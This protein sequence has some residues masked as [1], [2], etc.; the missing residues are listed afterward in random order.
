MNVNNL[1]LGQQIVGHVLELALLLFKDESAPGWLSL[2]LIAALVVLWTWHGLSAFRLRRAINAA[3]TVLDSGSGHITKERFIRIDLGFKELKDAREPRRR[4]AVAW[5]EFVETSIPPASES[6]PLSNTVRPAAFF[7]REE[8]GLDRGLWRQVPA[9]FVSV[10]LFLTFLGLVAALQ[11]TGQILVEARMAAD[12]A[13]TGAEGGG[14]SAGLEELL[15]IAKTKFI[16]SLTGLLCSI[17][18]TLVLRHYARRIDKAL[19]ALCDDIEDG[20]IFR[21]EQTILDQVLEQA[22]E[23]TEHL[24]TFSTELVAQIAAPLRDDLPNTIRDAMQQAMEPVIESISRG[25]NEGV[26]N[27]VDSVRDQLVAGIEESVLSMNEAIREVRR[28]LEVVTDRLDRSAD[29]MGERMDDA[30][31]RLVSGL[32]DATATMRDSLLDPLG[33]LVERIRGLTS[34]VGTAAERIDRYAEAVGNSETGIASANEALGR[35][36]ETLTAVSTPVRDAVSAI[37]STTGTMGD[38]V[39]TASEAMRQ[40]TAHTEA[41]LRSAREGIEA[42]RS[43]MSG[44]A[45][46]LESAVTKFGEIIN[47]YREIDQSLG[48]AFERIETAVRNSIDEI[49]TFARRLDEQFGSALNQLEA[50]IAQAEPFTPRRPGPEE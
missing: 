8:L 49:G 23:Q 47:S 50:V 39:E 18:F 37:A 43:A 45:G 33:I 21:S 27:L 19:H 1:D 9:L 31:Q 41:I 36:A 4:L 29:A 28:N 6:A 5:E 7:H 32:A 3:Q 16:M 20:C 14:V 46:S 40:T 12:G 30:A 34:A 15:K 25:T 17:I 35:S 38:R 2:A 42:S 48:D 24:K 11:E 22:K 26:E 13:E 10:G 44:A